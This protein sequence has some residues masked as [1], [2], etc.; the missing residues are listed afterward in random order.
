MIEVLY[1]DNH[2]LAV[3]KPAGVP[4]VPDASEDFSVLEMAKSW[5]KSEFQKSGNVFLGVV[6]RLDRPV[7]GIVVFAR[8]SKGAARLSKSWKDGE[9]KKWYQAFS[10][11]PWSQEKMEGEIEQWLWKDGKKNKVHLVTESRE[12]AKLAKTRWV[13]AAQ[14]N[15][16][17]FLW[18]EAVTGRAHQLRVACQSLQA[19]LAGDLKYGAE[20][21]YADG[22]RIGLHAARLEFPHPT[23]D[24]NI[25]ITADAVFWPSIAADTMPPA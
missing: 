8:T 1:S 19:P 25:S 24:E 11:S 21:P 13:L 2:I 14:E 20:N 23:R 7:S 17:T 5:V 18:L 16:N 6:H 22:R 4:V 3:L 15:G 9:V 12:G 10:C